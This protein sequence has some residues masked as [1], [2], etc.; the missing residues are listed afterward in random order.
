MADTAPQANNKAVAFHGKPVR[1]MVR[2]MVRPT[3][4]PA[5]AKKL[6]RRGMISEKQMHKMAGS[7]R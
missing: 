7:D 4:L 6:H 2:E 3:K 5:H 1:E